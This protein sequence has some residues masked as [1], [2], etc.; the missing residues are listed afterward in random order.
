MRDE[1]VPIQP[2]AIINVLTEWQADRVSVPRAS[3]AV[4]ALNARD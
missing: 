3:D 1:R 2:V 4:Q